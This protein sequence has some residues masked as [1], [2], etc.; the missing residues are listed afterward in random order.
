M[1]AAMSVIVRVVSMMELGL[2][3]AVKFDREKKSK[4]LTGDYYQLAFGKEIYY[5][6]TGTFPRRVHVEMMA[7]MMMIGSK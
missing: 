1:L 2:V 4:L 5:Y 7:M 3:G 6:L